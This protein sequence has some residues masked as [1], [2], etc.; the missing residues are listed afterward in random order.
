MKIIK[1]HEGLLRGLPKKQ[2]NTEQENE[3]AARIQAAKA[4]GI[5]DD[6]SIN[7]LALH[8]MREAFYYG[9]ACAKKLPAD[10]VY[11]LCYTGLHAAARNFAPN[12]IRF[13]AYSKAYVR[14]EIYRAYEDLKVVRKAEHQTLAPDTCTEDE[15]TE[16]HKMSLN[17]SDTYEVS[18][19]FLKS[20]IVESALPD[21]MARDDWSVLKPIMDDKLSEKER[22]VLQL[23]YEGDLNFRQIG[24]LLNVSRSDAQAT[25]TRAIKKLR[26]VLARK[27]GLITR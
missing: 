26:C 6:D 24:D 25:H 5:E 19:R 1:E 3:L 27:R 17:T 8:A 9:L 7:E 11:S 13:F 2:L 14:G 21:I 18:K 15:A 22:M 20:D 10:A 4:K 23:T 12:M 16:D